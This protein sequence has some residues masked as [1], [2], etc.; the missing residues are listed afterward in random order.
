MGHR[1]HEALAIDEGLAADRRFLCEVRLLAGL[2]A[3]L[4]RAA[5]PDER[6]GALLRAAF[7]HGLRDASCGGGHATLGE[8][9]PWIAAP[10]IPIQLRGALTTPGA[11]GRP[12]ALEGHWPA[13]LEAEAVALAG[14]ATRPA[15]LVSAAYTSGWLSALW[16][17][18]VLAVERSCAACGDAACRFEAREASAWTA[19]G[20]PVAARLLAALPF[21]LLRDRLA[22]ERRA[23]RPAC[24]GDEG[25]FDP[26]SPAVHVWGPVMVVPYAGDQT[27]VAVEAVSRQPAAAGVTVVVVDLQG[28]IVDDG[29]G[30]VALE[31]VVE[32]IEAHGAEA[33]LAGISPLSS[34]VVEGLG[35]APVVTRKDLRSAI[36]LA[37]QIAESQRHAV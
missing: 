29:F 6:R 34:R 25:A 23:Q 12:L 27:A 13:Q 22:R 28:A 2:H 20:D 21:G 37:F 14:G 10:A 18:D 16:E 33:V 32:V 15:C 19:S 7:L 3:E 35:R 11:A 36:A 17:A 31:R 9:A 30:A 26:A 24:D 8:G 1:H 5:R 4:V